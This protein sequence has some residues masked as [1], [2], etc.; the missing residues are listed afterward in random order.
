MPTSGEVRALS[1]LGAFEKG[2]DI[3][4][5]LIRLQNCPLER[6]CPI[7]TLPNSNY[8]MLK[9][10]SLNAQHT[11]AARTITAQNLRQPFGQ[12]HCVALVCTS[13]VIG[14]EK[15]VFLVCVCVRTHLC[16]GMCVL[17]APAFLWP[18]HPCCLIPWG[19]LVFGVAAWV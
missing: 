6:A 10:M 13:F 16:A 5:L 17:F 4:N 2:L 7:Y 1:A 11:A 12:N 14:E 18:I 9:W 8:L 15:N 3:V 19:V